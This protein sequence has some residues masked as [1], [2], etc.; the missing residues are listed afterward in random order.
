MVHLR[1]LTLHIANVRPL[2]SARGS[3]QHNDHARFWRDFGQVVVARLETLDVHLCIDM[4]M[5]APREYVR[6]HA[7]LQ[8]AN[9][10]TF[11]LPPDVPEDYV[12][13]LQSIVAACDASRIERPAGTSDRLL[14]SRC[15]IGRG[16]PGGALEWA[17]SSCRSDGRAR[18]RRG[19]HA[20][21]PTARARVLA[22]AARAICTPQRRARIARHDPRAARGG[23][24]AAAAAAPVRLAE[25]LRGAGC[26]SSFRLASY[27]QFG[28]RASDL[29]TTD[30]HAF[31]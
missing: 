11:E 21:S 16:S 2:L 18:A 10:R 30:V 15:R 8:Q 31:R 12:A 7:L 19:R 3:T 28:M 22:L 26:F 13:V 9:V 25:L 17:G 20:L 1:H 4:A 23:A 24:R 14:R 5:N 29:Q 27:T 6:R